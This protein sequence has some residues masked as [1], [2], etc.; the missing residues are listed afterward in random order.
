M[1]TQFTD[2]FMRY[3]QVWTIGQCM[4][5][6]ASVWNKQTKSGGIHWNGKVVMVVTAMTIT[7]D[8]KDTPYLALTG[9]L[10]GVF[11]GDLLENFINPG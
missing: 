2:T 1:M 9:E 4:F 7:G 8:T 5:T 10:W 11:C 6:T 3:Q